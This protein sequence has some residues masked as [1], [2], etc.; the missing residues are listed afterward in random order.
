[1]RLST[2]PE[3]ILSLEE[4][5]VWGIGP[6]QKMLKLY[7]EHFLD[8]ADAEEQFFYYDIQDRVDEIEMAVNKLQEVSR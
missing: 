2:L 3:S 4:I 8:D 5:Q 7:N 6:L 1:M